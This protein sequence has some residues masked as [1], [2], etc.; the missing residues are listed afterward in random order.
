M[1]VV[2]TAYSDE[3]FAAWRHVNNQGIGGKHHEYVFAFRNTPIAGESEFAL[4]D[5]QSNMIMCCI[6]T[7]VRAL[8]EDDLEKKYHIPNVWISDLT[9]EM[10]FAPSVSGRPV[11]ATVFTR[12]LSMIDVN[13]YYEKSH[14][15]GGLLIPAYA[16]LGKKR[17]E[18][19][20]K[21]EN[22]FVKYKADSFG[23]EQDGGYDLFQIYKRQKAKVETKPI[24]VR[25]NYTTN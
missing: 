2:K 23:D 4:Y 14:S 6:K 8:T 20:I 24:E 5:I 12:G 3:L 22:Y 1:L 21:N 7:D 15:P 16:K 10:N 13:A 19:I 17:G 9:S 18:L 11:Y 25:I